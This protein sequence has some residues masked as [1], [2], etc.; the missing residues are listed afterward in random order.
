M[1]PPSNTGMVLVSTA[2]LLVG[3]VPSEANAAAVSA[4]GALTLPFNTSVLERAARGDD[5]GWAIIP[6]VQCVDR[7]EQ[8]HT[9]SLGSEREDCAKDLSCLAIY[10]YGCNGVGFFK[11][12]STATKSIGLSES[13]GSQSCV[14]MPSEN[15]WRSTTLNGDGWTK[16]DGVMCKSQGGQEYKFL[17]EM[18][19]ICA[20]DPTCVAIADYG[21]DGNGFGR[22]KQIPAADYPDRGDVPTVLS[23]TTCVHANFDKDWR[24][25]I[26]DA[27]PA[28]AAPPPAPPPA[29]PG[30]ACETSRDCSGTQC[31]NKQCCKADVATACSSCDDGGFCN[32]DADKIK[33]GAKCETSSQ[34]K[35]G[36]CKER[37]CKADDSACSECDD[38]GFCAATT[39]NDAAKTQAGSLCSS[40]AECKSG[41]CKERCCKADDSACSECDSSGFCAKAFQ[42][43]GNL[44][45][46]VDES[47]CDLGEEY[48]ATTSGCSPCPPGTT[49]LERDVCTACDGSRNTTT[50]TITGHDGSCT[51]LMIAERTLASL[52]AGDTVDADG[53]TSGGLDTGTIVGIVVSVVI[54][55]IGMIFMLVKGKKDAENMN[56]IRNAIGDSNTIKQNP[57]Y[58]D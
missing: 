48:I 12:T 57:A 26:L 51:A 34:C 32:E 7:I 28:P 16:Q 27:L 17:A 58:T 21:C 23:T 36:P 3:L 14:H 45:T 54:A 13:T 40:S 18:T 2:A 43:D 24:S 29:V 47:K 55:G 50:Y 10:D 8:T 6:D 15:D 39:G 9:R 35:S 52:T 44:A 30:D 46:I 49:M 22:C 1:L 37:C 42:S 53:S 41:P 25:K 5:D 33:D 56:M 38:G 11:C 20:Q 4:H 31:K 19:A